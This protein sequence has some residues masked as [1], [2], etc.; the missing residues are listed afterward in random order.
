[1]PTSPK[2]IDVGSN[3]MAFT[4]PIAAGGHLPKR[5]FSSISLPK[6]YRCASSEQTLACRQFKRVDKNPSDRGTL[7][8][9]AHL[10]ITLYLLT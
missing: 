10:H 4:T 6:A 8:V 1:M 9:C 2:P 3:L 5:H 7:A